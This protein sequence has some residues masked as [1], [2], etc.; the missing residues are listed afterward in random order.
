MERSSIF[1]GKKF[2]I[3]IDSWIWR[4]EIQ[5]RNRLLNLAG[6]NRQQKSTSYRY[7]NRHPSPSTITITRRHMVSIVDH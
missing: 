3:E 5:N 1:G 6:R 4:E 7:D 2:K